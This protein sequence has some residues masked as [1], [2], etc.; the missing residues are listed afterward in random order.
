M[1]DII[2]QIIKTILN[3]ELRGNITPDEFNKIAKQVQDEIVEEY[4]GD[5]NAQQNKRNRG[6]VNIGHSSL[7][8]LIS[9]KID[10]FRKT[11]VLVYDEPVFELPDDMYFI[12]ENGIVSG[13]NVV[14]ESKTANLAYM[15]SSLGAPSS[16]FPVFKME[17]NGII[18][19]PTSIVSGVSCTYIRRP[20]DPKWTYTSIGNVELF[21]DT[22][23]DYQDFE[24][25]VSELSNIVIRM[26][27]YLG[28]NIR[29]ADV[30]QYAES[31]KQK[32][33]IKEQQ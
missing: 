14:E 23:N 21:D 20:L 19:Y 17:G 33:E 13:G 11:S 29:E 22:I 10:I 6:L 2:Y 12:E 24:L 30:V 3:K 27:S 1:I 25:H 4:F 15:T 28:I 7:T 16:T 5:I 8:K 31:L 32:E 18:V 9:Q 26:L